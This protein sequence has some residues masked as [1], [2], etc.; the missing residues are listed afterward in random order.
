VSKK[1]NKKNNMKKIFTKEMLTNAV[2]TLGVVMIALAVHEKYVA[3]MLKGTAT[4]G[5]SAPT[6]TP[7]AEA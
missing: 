6:T 7:S 2:V 5:G 3:P 4:G 1:L